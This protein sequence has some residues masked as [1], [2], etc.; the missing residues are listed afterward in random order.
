MYQLPL[1]ADDFEILNSRVQ[2]LQWESVGVT[3]VLGSVYE[4]NL[5]SS[6]SSGLPY[7][8][9]ECSRCEV[10]REQL[11]YEYGVLKSDHFLLN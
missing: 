1:F 5:S 7:C 8:T 3:F 6:P 4:K 9:D 2:Q 10:F 11:V